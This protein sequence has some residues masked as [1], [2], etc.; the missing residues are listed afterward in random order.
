MS[1]NAGQAVLGTTGVLALLL[2][3]YSQLHVALYVAIVSGGGVGLFLLCL[4]RTYR[5]GMALRSLLCV[6]AMPVLA[7]LLPAVGLTGVHL[8]H[9]VMCLWVPVFAGSRER[10][11]P[12]YLFS[13][14]LLPG[15]DLAVSLGS[16]KLFDFGVQDGLAVG[17]AAAIWLRPLGARRRKASDG[18]VL[19]L[20]LM[21]GISLSRETSATNFLR[22]SVNL[23]L[24]LGLPYYILSR[25]IADVPGQRAAL[26]WFACGGVALSAILLFEAS[27][28]W[29]IYNDLYGLYNVPVELLVKARGG[30]LR[31]GGPFVE[32]TSIAL[33][34]AMCF[35]ALSLLREDFRSRLRHL[36]LL[37]L[38]FLGVSAPQSRGAWIGLA[39]AV[40]AMAV[41]RGR[42]R[43]LLLNAGTI[44]IFLGLLLVTAKM[45]PEFAEALGLSEGNASDTTTYRRDLFEKGKE[46][47]RL[48]PLTGHSM[49][50]LN[51]LMAELRQGEGIIDFVNTYLWIALIGGA[52]GLTVFIGNFVD[53]LAALWRRRGGL[54]RTP[55][56]APA[57]FVFGC[58]VMLAEMLFFTS[59][60]GRPAFLTF[61]LFGLAAS[62]LA[63]RPRP[64]PR[65][66]LAEIPTAAT[67]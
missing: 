31:A 11:A 21:L 61:G 48:S 27:R 18:W 41:Y 59:F 50:R 58:L 46:V 64:Y 4:R 65:P 22:T 43:A 29:P 52:L 16:L 33:V 3:A 53:P 62:I 39:L 2:L 10:I 34:L 17:A 42:W 55:G 32:P 66:R 26:R 67:A 57:A 35:A 7:W 54:R 15:L 45:S 5:E 6:V 23:V 44:G 49:P 19:A 25:G 1:R 30:M 36:G 40:V 13:L 63:E 9:L 12:V 8:L 51:V 14:L 20:L 60:G 28:S 38:V 37:A 24:D 47:F 56:Q